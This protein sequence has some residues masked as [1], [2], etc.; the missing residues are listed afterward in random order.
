MSRLT[1]F[2]SANDRVV[3]SLKK[4]VDAINALEPDLERLSDVEL[5]ARTDQF[6]REVVRELEQCMASGGYKH[7]ILAGTADATNRVRA[8]LPK[9]LSD[10]LVDYVVAGKRDETQDVVRATLATFIDQEQ[11]ESLTR[12]EELRRE[13]RARGLAAIG[14]RDTD[15]QVDVLIV[16]R[17]LDPELKEPLVRLAEQTSAEIETVER[18]EWLMDNEGA[19][20]LL[21]YWAPIIDETGE[22][23]EF[24]SVETAK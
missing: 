21:R 15:G 22:A 24:A 17:E 1:I 11:R 4:T 8:F 7:L 14:Y 18:S 10:V 3:K 23:V 13:L 19:G 12:V 2:G 16:A 6:F 20:A 9:H 5:R